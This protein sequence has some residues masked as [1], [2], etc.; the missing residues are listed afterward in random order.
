LASLNFCSTKL[1]QVSKMIKYPEYSV[2][3]YKI[4]GYLEVFKANVSMM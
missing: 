3:E 2:I 1:G 4:E